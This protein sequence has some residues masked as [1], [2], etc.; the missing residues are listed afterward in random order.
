MITTQ[1]KYRRY[2]CII[3]NIV[4]L[5]AIFFISLS[6]LNGQQPLTEIQIIN[7]SINADYLPYKK[8]FILKGSAILQK[9]TADVIAIKISKSSD[10]AAHHESTWYRKFKEKEKEFQFVIDKPL[11]FDEEYKIELTYYIKT[12]LGH[13]LMKTVI[14]RAKKRSIQ[15]AIGGTF[16]STTIESE[17][18]AVLSQISAANQNFG[19]ITENNGGITFYPGVTISYPGMSDPSWQQLLGDYAGIVDE[20][21]SNTADIA[22]ALANVKAYT[23]DP[24]FSALQTWLLQ[25][26]RNNSRLTFM[27]DDVRQLEHIAKLKLAESPFGRIRHDINSGQLTFTRGESVYQT[28]IVNLES[29]FYQHAQKIEERPELKLQLDYNEKELDAVDAII[30]E[31]VTSHGT[32]VKYAETFLSKSELESIRIGTTFGFSYTGLAYQENEFDQRKLSGDLFMY[33]GL[34]FYFG[35]VDKDLKDPYSL[36]GNPILNRL[37]LTFGVALSSINFKGTDV[38]NAAG[39]KPMFGFSY[40]LT[41]YITLDVGTVF[42][43]NKSISSLSDRKTLFGRPFIGISFD[44][45]LFNQIRKISLPKSN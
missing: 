14:E 12:G 10:G 23:N 32:S 27:P 24:N 1:K 5:I 17:V 34:K 35:P 20:Y 3:P 40:D 6:I 31:G 15:A 45:N 21:N 8:K 13:D 37:A 18:N 42:F 39:L 11:E 44:A 41:R 2:C 33:G 38:E 26:K 19:Y 28:L 36:S 30:R 25:E 29:S 16:T 9:D 22:S 4:T 7:G 43:K